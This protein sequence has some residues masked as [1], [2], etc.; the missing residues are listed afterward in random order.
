MSVWVAAEGRDH[1]RLLPPAERTQEPVQRPEALKKLNRPL[2]HT[3][4]A[5][6]WH[7]AVW[8]VLN[9]HTHRRFAEFV[10]YVAVVEPDDHVGINPQHRFVAAL[11]ERDKQR[12]LRP[13]WRSRDGVDVGRRRHEQI[14]P[15]SLGVSGERRQSNVK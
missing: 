6:A 13:R 5:A 14:V 7:R 3:P 2:P 8:C 9:D 15:V 12:H 11:Q 4:D 10:K 1:G